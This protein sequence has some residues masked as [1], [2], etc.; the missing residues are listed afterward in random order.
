VN[1]LLS[2]DLISMTPW[3]NANQEFALW[4]WILGCYILYTYILCMSVAFHT[5]WHVRTRHIEI[6]QPSCV[7][8]QVVSF[9]KKKTSC[10][11]PSSPN[12]QVVTCPRSN[13]QSEQLIYQL[14]IWICT[15]GWMMLAS[16][17]CMGMA[18]QH[19]CLISG[20]NI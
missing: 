3:H 13:A 5:V 2:V 14:S 1:V 11:V 4:V 20:D 10:S 15:V 17:V 8:R 7:N 18:S 9:Q 12:F 16:Y 19:L 6:L